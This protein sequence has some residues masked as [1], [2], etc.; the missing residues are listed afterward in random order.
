MEIKAFLE[1]RVPTIAILKC[2]GASRRLILAVYFFQIAAVAAA[3]IL[4]GLAIGAL[5]PWAAVAF[6]GDKLPVVARLGVYPQPLAQAAAFGALTTLAFAAWPL[7][8]AG[9]VPAATLFRDIVVPRRVWPGPG[10]LAVIGAAGLALAGL[11]VVSAADRSLAGWFVG[12]SAATLALFVAAGHAL[13]GLTRWAARR[14]AER[15]GW[16]AL[17]LAL[18]SLHRPGAPTQS[19]VLSLGLGLTVLVA[20][21]LVEANLSREF[22]ERMPDQAPTFLF[23]DIQPD[24]V[25]AFDRAVNMAGGE[26]KRAAMCARPHHAD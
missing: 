10:A 12:A 3:G 25:E 13:V 4:I 18:S 6:F 23:I 7:A 15:G 9:A 22:K 19:V 14:R 24:Q 17:R 11:A 16:P 21:A 20:V 8:S 1:A 2:L 5:L 26:A